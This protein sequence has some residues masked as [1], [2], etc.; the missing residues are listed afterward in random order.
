MILSGASQVALNP[1]N[2]ILAIVTLYCCCIGIHINW[3]RARYVRIYHAAK[4]GPQESV[5]ALEILHIVVGYLNSVQSLREYIY[6]IK[7]IQIFLCISWLFDGFNDV[8]Y[9]INYYGGLKNLRLKHKEMKQSLYV[10]LFYLFFYQFVLFVWCWVYQIH[11]TYVVAFLWINLFIYS[12]LSHKLIVNKMISRFESQPFGQPVL[13]PIFILWILLT[14]SLCDIN[15]VVFDDYNKILKSKYLVYGIL[16][17]T[18]CV[19]FGFVGYT[20]TNM[21][22]ILKVNYLTITPKHANKNEKKKER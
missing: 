10:E 6:I 16:V 22:R 13:F 4:I 17:W 11:I 12:H 7:S 19:F 14:L 9:T 15:N 8:R 2:D 20:L 21:K 18:G 1:M 3:L 5:S